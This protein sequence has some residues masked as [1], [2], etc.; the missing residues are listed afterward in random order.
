MGAFGLVK[1]LK[2]SDLWGGFA[3]LDGS[4][5]SRFLTSFGMTG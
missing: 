5:D 3:V 4:E 1:C 2:V